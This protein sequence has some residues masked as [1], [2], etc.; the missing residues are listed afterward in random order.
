MC[1]DNPSQETNIEYLF[2]LTSVVNVEVVMQTGTM[3]PK[4]DMCRLR[5]SVW[6]QTL[7]M[8]CPL[9]CHARH[10]FHSTVYI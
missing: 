8:S 9:N 7:E 10:G 3:L 6:R 1:T 5:G 2:A 4:V